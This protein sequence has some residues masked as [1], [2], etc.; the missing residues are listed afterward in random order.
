MMLSVRLRIRNIRERLRKG[1]RQFLDL[2]AHHHAEKAL[3]FISFAES[4]FFPIPPDAWLIPMVLARPRRAF[5]IAGIATAAS[6]L[7]G[8]LGY[9]LG[10][11]FYRTVGEPLLHFYG[12]TDTFTTFQARY[13]QWG[14]WAVLA[15]GITPFPYKAITILSGLT[16]LNFGIFMVSSIIARGLRFY[17]VAGLLWWFGPPIQNFLERYIGWVLT[18]FF[19]LLF[20]GFWVVHYAG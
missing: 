9:L 10:Y 2:A 6:V 12:Y 8:V 16:R 4:S 17:L 3:A 11:F 5:R 14:A 20:G 1:Y 15:A 18:A 7:G 13:H 19:L